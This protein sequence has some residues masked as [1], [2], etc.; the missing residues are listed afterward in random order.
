M[1]APFARRIVAAL[2]AIIAA[3]ACSKDRSRSNASRSVGVRSVKT[4]DS[5]A[6][7]VD[8]GALGYKAEP[9]SAIGSI[10]GTIKLD[11]GPR[12]DVEPV[13]VDQPFCGKAVDGAVSATARGLSNSIV[14]IADVKSGKSLPLSLIHISEPTRH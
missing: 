9:L 5:A 2:L 1:T 6:G 8:L 10:S 4:R 7:S 12:K 11:G 14:W 13:T 3:A